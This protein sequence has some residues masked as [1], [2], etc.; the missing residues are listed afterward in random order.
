MLPLFSSLLQFLQD[1]LDTLFGILDESS[2]RYGLKVFD[3]LVSKLFEKIF[4]VFYVSSF[5]QA[6]SHPVRKQK[7]KPTVGRKIQWCNATQPA[8]PISPRLRCAALI[9]RGIDLS[10]SAH[11]SLTLT[12]EQTPPAQRAL[13][14]DG[15]VERA[16]ALIKFPFLWCGDQ[17]SESD[18]WTY[19][20]WSDRFSAFHT[21]ETWSWTTV[22]SIVFCLFF[23]LDLFICWYIFLFSFCPHSCLF[24][25]CC[26]VILDPQESTVE[27]ITVIKSI[28][29]IKSKI[30]IRLWM[31]AKNIIKSMWISL[32]IT[33]LA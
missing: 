6:Q 31:L 2:Q 7:R 12:Y 14:N 29:V 19:L 8:E 13:I 27:V 18:K 33:V 30:L 22:E 24:D 9:E 21:R 15:K 28:K 20:L 3:S 16:A 17:S 26:F 1:T 5:S 32:R 25:A 11:I 23:F 4:F 10:L